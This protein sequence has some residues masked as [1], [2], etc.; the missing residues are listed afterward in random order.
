MKLL[1]KLLQLN[2][3]DIRKGMAPDNIEDMTIPWQNLVNMR[4]MQNGI[5][6][7]AG[8]SALVDVSIGVASSY[9]LMD[10]WNY[11]V[12]TGTY[13][14]LVGVVNPTTHE[15]L[16][17]KLDSAGTFTLTNTAKKF[18]AIEH[19]TG[20][21]NQVSTVNWGEW[22][23]ICC[24]V[25]VN[26][27]PGEGLLLAK[28]P[29]GT[30][31]AVVGAGI[32]R[33]IFLHS[34]HVL[35][36]NYPGNTDR[37][38]WCTADDIETWTVTAANSA[39]DLNIREFAGIG[40]VCVAALG[41]SIAAYS[42]EGMAVISYIGAP[43]YYGY[44]MAIPDSIGA[45][46][47]KAVVAVG[48]NNYGL[49]AKGFFKTD[50]V[51]YEWIGRDRIWEYFLQTSSGFNLSR[52]VAVHLES[53]T[54]IW[55]TITSTNFAAPSIA[56]VYNYTLDAWFQSNL[57]GNG[58]MPEVGTH[59]AV[60][61]YQSTVYQKEIGNQIRLVSSFTNYS[62][63]ATSKATDFGESSIYKFLQAVGIEN[64]LSNN[65]SPYTVT[66]T[67]SADLVSGLPIALK[68]STSKLYFALVTGR[69][70]SLIITENS[71]SKLTMLQTITFYGKASGGAL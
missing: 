16:V 31:A 64:N 37:F 11:S 2:Y 21:I 14:G 25:E 58:A 57:T 55:W 66:F 36:F 68:L 5:L 48:N 22:R 52:T 10:N 35:G 47:Q 3:T 6:P 56:F 28:Y 7:I 41:K 34:P 20:I 50:G 15:L 23:A 67:A 32:P 19:G 1:P 44:E 38:A 18:S 39:G 46:S 42:S 33:S 40:I 29:A 61:G 45:V 62:S 53:K 71:T 8:L 69:Y 60:Q 70:F 12:T 43:L 63:S 27:T 26:G 59:P 17:Y 30:Y 51:N 49:C 65:A 4:P 9:F 54:E 24:G 13:Y